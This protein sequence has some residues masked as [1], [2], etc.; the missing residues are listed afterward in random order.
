M[1]P[2]FQNYLLLAAAIGLTVFAGVLHGRLSQRWTGQDPAGEAAKRLQ[3]FAPQLEHWAAEEDHVL[4]QAVKD[5]LQCRGY[6][7]RSYVNRDT[8]ESVNVAVL[9][10]PAGPISVHTP[11]ICYSS[12]EFTLA[13][14]RRKVPISATSEKQS[15]FWSV[16]FQS[17]RVEGTPLRVYYAWTADGRWE[18]AENPR[19][20]FAGHPMLFKIQLAAQTATLGEDNDPGRRFLQEFL[21]ALDKHVIQPPPDPARTQ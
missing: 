18:A 8:G 14:Q 2:R 9:V 19:F 5:E 17:V 20:H 3:T 16:D 4:A 21:P 7:H 1:M 12:R 11:E 6:L 15:H 13:S 10:G